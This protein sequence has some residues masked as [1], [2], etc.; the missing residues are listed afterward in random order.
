[1]EIPKHILRHRFANRPIK[2]EILL[3]EDLDSLRD[4]YEAY[5]GS[6]YRYTSAVSAAQAISLLETG[7]YDKV[8]CDYYL[9]RGSLGTEV[10]GWITENQPHVLDKFAFV[11]VR[12]PE[13]E[14]LGVP[15]IDKGDGPALKA[16][17]SG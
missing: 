5:L 6:E 16:W 3:I 11:C 1:M 12:C 9:T 7:E 13:V 17:V 15:V 4:A 2:A 10:L 8:V 14:G